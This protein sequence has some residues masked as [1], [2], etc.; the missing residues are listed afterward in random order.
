MSQHCIWSTL[1]SKT[2]VVGYY[3]LFSPIIVQINFIGQP[4][5]LFSLCKP[6]RSL[7]I[8]LQ[9]AIAKRMPF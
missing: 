3:D 9:T 4:F 5:L 2:M 8:G 7:D 6:G 1:L